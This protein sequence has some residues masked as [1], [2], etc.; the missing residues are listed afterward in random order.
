MSIREGIAA[1]L[2][3]YTLI[4][5]EI[6]TYLIENP[7]CLDGDTRKAMAYQIA[8]QYFSDKQEL[9]AS[10]GHESYNWP[11]AIKMGLLIDCHSDGDDKVKEEYTIKMAKQ[12]LET[13]PH[14]LRMIPDE[15]SDTA[16][17]IVIQYLEQQK[18]S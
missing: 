4:S 13:T 8:I 2:E 17:K 1:K 6:A 15:I 3:K 7:H 11:E 12:L 10:L 5:S 16:F 14:W 18:S 9:S